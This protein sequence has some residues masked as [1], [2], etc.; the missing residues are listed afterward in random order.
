L[1]KVVE[2]VYDIEYLHMPG[3]SFVPTIAIF[4]VILNIFMS[5]M[6]P[7]R[8]LLL[9]SIRNFH[10]MS[11][12]LQFVVTYSIEIITVLQRNIILILVFHS[13]S[14]RLQFVVTHSIEVIFSIFI[15]IMLPR[16]QLLLVAII[17]F[18]STS[19]RLQFVVNYSIGIITVLLRCVIAS[20]R[21]CRILLQHQ[22]WSAVMSGLTVPAPLLEIL[23]LKTWRA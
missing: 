12:T 18:H 2:A 15:S 22:L 9:V 13:A 16:R 5:I 10:G 1:G 3:H 8:L 17:N 14:P 19:P 21:H 20:A 4:V 7:R 6:L 23:K 11:P